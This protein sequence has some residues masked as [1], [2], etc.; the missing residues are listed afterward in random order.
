MNSLRTLNR[1]WLGLIGVFLTV[2]F[3]VGA[4]FVGSPSV[5]ASHF[6]LLAPQ[7]LAVPIV[8]DDDL[9][10]LLSLSLGGRD[11]AVVAWSGMNLFERQALRDQAIRITTMAQSAERDGILSCPD[12]ARTLRWGTASFLAEAWEGRILSELNLT[13]EA[14]RS[15]YEANRQWYMDERGAPIPFEQIRAR[16]RDDMIRAAVLERMEKLSP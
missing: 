11:V 2:L 13:E 8:D 4:F 12:V 7:V 3:L 6:N 16:V 15:F 1:S 9:I 5:A 14:A 10:A